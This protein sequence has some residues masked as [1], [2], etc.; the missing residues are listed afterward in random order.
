MIY[1]DRLSVSSL[2][3]VFWTA[4][5]HR[6]RRREQLRLL[7]FAST[8]GGKRF[9]GWLQP[10]GL[11]HGEE[12]HFNYVDVQ[13]EDGGL[14]GLRAELMDPI[15]I[16]GSIRADLF[17]C[18][19]LIGRLAKEFSRQRLMLFLEKSLESELNPVLVRISVV[20]WFHRQADSCESTRAIYMVRRTPW[21]SYLQD[22]ARAKRV[23]LCQYRQLSLSGT[24][25]G[26][27]LWAIVARFTGRLT[28]T[29]VGKRALAGDKVEKTVEQPSFTVAVPFTSM[30][31]TRDLSKNTELFWVPFSRLVPDQLLVYALRSDDPLDQDKYSDLRQSHIRAVALRQN[32]RSTAS[33]PLWPNRSD[34]NILYRELRQTWKLLAI[35]ILASFFSRGVNRWVGLKML[36]FSLHYVYWHWFFTCF[37]V[38][39]LVDRDKSSD[40]TLAHD[41]AIADL[42]GITIGYQ[43]AD[44]AF[45]NLTQASA[46]DLRFVFSRT[47]SEIGRQSGSKVSY[48]V[49]NGYIH[50]HAFSLVPD[51]AAQVRAALTSTGVRFIVCF[52]DEGSADDRRW[53]LSHEFMADNYR[54]L[55]DKLFA[56]PTLGLVLKPKSPKSLRRRLGE[57]AQKLDAALETGRCYMYEEGVAATDA[58]PCEASLTADV[59][60]GILYGS[61]A[62]MEC[63][64][65]GSLSL[66]VDRERVTYH[67]L[68]RLG[69]GRVVFPNWENL[70]D[71]LCAYRKDPRSLS[72]FG[73][74]SPL[75]D[76][77][78][79]FR[80]GKAAQ[81]MGEY[82]GWLAESLTKGLSPDNAM[83]LAW[84]KYVDQWGDDKVVNLRAD[85]VPSSQTIDV[86]QLAP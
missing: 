16:C 31:L 80:D 26:W 39:I 24:L 36:R 69:E 47:G 34:L 44:E 78:D 23:G 50:D 52:L 14:L 61:T 13:D 53:S 32:A 83:E 5:A 29:A 72:G 66:L 76:D 82:I 48:F 54:F 11:I 12:A 42:G 2:V 77:L 30:R 35:P 40:I 59:T 25:P 6:I 85:S 86:L 18:N 67:P 15:P 73:D 33:V 63:A 75:L 17:E 10:L 22:Y 38:K 51:R 81:R 60:I 21:F 8:N 1:L 4:L 46:T 37:K 19:H 9:L 74:W 64:L 28:R 70:W 55:L 84:Q 3:H 49:A 62:S 65:A 45:A 56:D 71:V 43:L 7:F 57:V 27:T 20:A 79:P 68:Y 58:L 41:Q